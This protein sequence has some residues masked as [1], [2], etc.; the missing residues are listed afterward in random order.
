MKCRHYSAAGGSY[1]MPSLL[2]TDPIPIVYENATGVPNVTTVTNVPKMT[3]NDPSVPVFGSVHFYM[4][5]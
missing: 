4:S 2:N 5:F 3:K 1:L